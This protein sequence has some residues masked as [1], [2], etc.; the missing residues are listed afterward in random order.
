MPASGFDIDRYRPP[1]SRFKSADAPASPALIISRP[2]PCRSCHS[3]L[4]DAFVAQNAMSFSRYFARWR[5]HAFHDAGLI[6]LPRRHMPSRLV[7]RTFVAEWPRVSMASFA[8]RH[9]DYHADCSLMA[10]RRCCW[11]F[12]SCRD[13]VR[14][15]I[16]AAIYAPPCLSFSYSE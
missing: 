12:R 4:D 6:F 13:A 2:P 3:R 8:L 11:R 16:F 15:L 14:I 1:Y 9:A 5:F 10:I 7:R